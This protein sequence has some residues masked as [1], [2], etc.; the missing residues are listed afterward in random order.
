MPRLKDWLKLLNLGATQSHFGCYAPAC[1]TDKWLQRYAFMDKVGKRSWP[2]FGA[3]YMVQAVK[4]VKGMHLI[5]PAWTKKS[6]PAP[7]GV[8]ATNKR[9]EQQDG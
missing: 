7:A 6:A 3:V 2:Y 4:R 1:R 8:P 5:G 9:R